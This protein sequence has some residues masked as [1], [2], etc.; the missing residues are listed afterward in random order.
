MDQLKLLLY[1]N[2]QCN[3]SAAFLT[4]DKCFH[5]DLNIAES[6]TFVTLWLFFGIRAGYPVA[7][8]IF[9]QGNWSLQKL[10]CW[11]MHI[12]GSFWKILAKKLNRK[13]LETPNICYILE[14]LGLKD[15]YYENQAQLPMCQTAFNFNSRLWT[16]RYNNHGRHKGADCRQTH[17]AEWEKWSSG[18]VSGIAVKSGLL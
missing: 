3:S 18:D 6:C 4:F 11:L 10:L 17:M 5:V 13:T 7:P 14:N 8:S 1:V 12:W 15:S 2:F 9:A 16:D